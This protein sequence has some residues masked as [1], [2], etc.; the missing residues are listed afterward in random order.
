MARDRDQVLRNISSR[1]QASA[2]EV[3]V[4]NGDKLDEAATIVARRVANWPGFGETRTSLLVQFETGDII[5]ELCRPNSARPLN[6][7]E[8]IC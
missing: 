1:S 6:S 2:L 8:T 5:S 4:E 3:L 7:C